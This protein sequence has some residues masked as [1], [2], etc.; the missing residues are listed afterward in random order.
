VNNGLLTLA[1]NN[2]LSDAEEIRV[3][4]PEVWA[5]IGAC[6]AQAGAGADV[7]RQRDADKTMAL[8]AAGKKADRDI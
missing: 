1:V 2:A 3:Q 5:A 8:A 4:K 6:D 7:R